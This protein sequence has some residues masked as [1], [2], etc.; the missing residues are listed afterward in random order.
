MGRCGGWSSLVV[1]SPPRLE[2]AVA[3]FLCVLLAGFHAAGSVVILRILT[4]CRH[5]IERLNALED[6]EAKFLA[7]EEKLARQRQKQ[8]ATK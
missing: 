8:E 7:H 3:A 2:P 1:V 5:H 4:V 6:I